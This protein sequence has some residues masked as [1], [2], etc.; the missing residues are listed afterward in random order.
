[1][2]DVR[3]GLEMSGCCR[4]ELGCERLLKECLQDPG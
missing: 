4:S 1:M 3:A 2:D